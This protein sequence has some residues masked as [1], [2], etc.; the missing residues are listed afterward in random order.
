MSLFYYDGIDSSGDRLKSLIPNC[1]SQK[2]PCS[3]T[4]PFRICECKTQWTR[5]GV[6]IMWTWADNRIRS[7]VD[8]DAACFAPKSIL[9][10]HTK[11]REE[12]LY[13]AMAYA[14]PL[15]G[16]IDRIASIAR[17]GSSMVVGCYLSLSMFVLLGLVGFVMYSQGVVIV[18]GTNWLKSSIAILL[19][20]VL[21]FHRTSLQKITLAITGTTL[22]LAFSVFLKV[23]NQR[24]P[25][26]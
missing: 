3:I 12:A 14:S 8:T 21:L 4:H 25:L 1:L 22:W 10:R 23:I 16:T 7:I 11:T 24:N 13:H 6:D 26:N 2:I 15:A 9:N 5:D 18:S 17:F 19:N 20:L